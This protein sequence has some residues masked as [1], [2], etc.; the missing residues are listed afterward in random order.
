MSRLAVCTDFDGTV[1]IPDACDYLLERFAAREWKE[2]DDAVWRGDL[3]ER[4][5]FPRQIELLRVSWD[6]ARKALLDGVRIR[7]GFPEF[8]EFCR[9]QQIPL[10]VL[11]SGLR[12]LI[13][14]LLESVG[15]R[16][17]SVIAHTTEIVGDR[18]RVIP[19]TGNR[20]AEHCSHCKCADLL[21]LTDAGYDVVYIGDGY[22]DLCPA[23]RATT[24]F[25]TGNLARSCTESHRPFIPFDTFHDIR[26]HLSRRI[27]A[28]QEL[29]L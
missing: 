19:W 1:C 22:T 5:A 15:V 3:L 6:E 21:T 16:D 29:S 8:V 2:L 7:E 23:E 10:T 18:W 9:V 27:L 12:E 24:L 25:A 4:A 17:V 20:L 14:A 13:V 11:S 26:R 28:D